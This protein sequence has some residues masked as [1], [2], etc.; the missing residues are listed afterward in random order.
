ME[1]ISGSHPMMV[2]PY[3]GFDMLKANNE[4]RTFTEA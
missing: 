2:T 3:L 4:P 1:E